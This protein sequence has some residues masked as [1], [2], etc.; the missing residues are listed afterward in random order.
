MGFKQVNRFAN[1]FPGWCLLV[2]LLL[3]KNEFASSFSSLSSTPPWTLFS[4]YEKVLKGKYN[5]FYDF[6]CGFKSHILSNVKIMQVFF[7]AG[8]W[9]QAIF[10]P[11]RCKHSLPPLSQL[12]VLFWILWLPL[13]L[14]NTLSI[15]L[16]MSA[17]KTAISINVLIPG[18]F[19][20]GSF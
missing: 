5:G 12:S 3:S 8:P 19:I 11:Q 17:L 10:Q 6:V 18:I 15:G 13:I 9:W 4:K 7:R 2:L 16:Q 20:V 14:N 1:H